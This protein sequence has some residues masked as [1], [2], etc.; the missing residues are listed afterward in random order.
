M[1]GS[2][3]WKVKSCTHNTTY[4][5]ALEQAAAERTLHRTHRACFT[6]HRRRPD[7]VG[8]PPCRWRKRGFTVHAHCGG[9]RKLKKTQARLRSLA[10]LPIVA[11]RADPAKLRAADA[12]SRHN[13]GSRSRGAGRRPRLLRA[14]GAGST[15][16][17]LLCKTTTADCAGCGQVGGP[18]LP[19]RHAPSPGSPEEPSMRRDRR[20]TPR[21]APGS[22]RAHR[23]QFAAVARTGVAD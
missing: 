5:R 18:T 6:S 7:R 21:A 2:R 9:I 20:D 14:Q 22:A 8:V 16:A 4:T 23:R 13:A 1:K 12:R 3:G 10:H 11:P 19:L 17:Y 15:Q